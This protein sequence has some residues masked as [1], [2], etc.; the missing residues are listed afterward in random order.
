MTTL[1]KPG[2]KGEQVLS[3]QDKL[4]KLGLAVNPDGQF[5]PAT[6]QAVEEL[7]ATFGY[8]ADGIVGDA[9]A[10]LIDA[11]LGYGW[12]LDAPDG[13]KRALQ[14]QGKKSADGSLTGAALSRTLKRGLDGVD[15]RLLQRRLNALGF[16]VAVDGK[17]GEATENAVRALQKSFGYDVDGVVGEATHKLLNQQIGNGWIAGA[18]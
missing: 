15:V 11:Q 13:I 1:L 9:T 2:A 10:K 4:S 12:K 6:K 8:D 14:A 5:G 16:G 18:S 3:L 17:F 7:Q